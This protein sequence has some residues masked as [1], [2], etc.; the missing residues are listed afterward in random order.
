M[1]SVIEARTIP[2]LIPGVISIINVARTVYDAT[3]DAKG[4]LEAFRQVAARLPLVNDIFNSV[5]GSTQTLDES[6]RE[7][8]KLIL[9]SC[10]AKGK[11]LEKVF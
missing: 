11:N 7:A 5:R 8:L 1:T 2:G 3:K 9:E 6:T 4:Q 10:K